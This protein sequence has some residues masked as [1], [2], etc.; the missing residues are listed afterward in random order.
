MLTT[1]LA[2]NKNYKTIDTEVEYALPRD[3]WC[4]DFSEC[5]A[6]QQQHRLSYIFKIFREIRKPNVN[7]DRLQK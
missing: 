4:L 3:E 1:C 5:P 6:T 7:I 2:I